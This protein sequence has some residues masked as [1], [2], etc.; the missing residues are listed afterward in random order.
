MKPASKPP[1]LARSLVLISVAALLVWYVARAF[2]GIPSPPAAPL[3]APAVDQSL[4][5]KSSTQVA[6]F[7][8]GC[9]WG[10]QAVFEHVIGV[11]KVTAG[12]CGGHVDHPYYE[13]VCTGSTGH[14]ESARVV[15]DPS[16]IT[17]G[18]LLMIFFGVAHDPT[19]NNRQGPDVGT[20]Y[21]SAIFYTTDEQ[22]KIA[23]AYIAQLDARKLFKHA[24]ATEL[25]HAP[26]FYDAEDYHQDYLVHHM[27]DG[28]I[29]AMD[30]P[31]LDRLK[32][33]FPQF[34]R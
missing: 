13:L 7:A 20:Q 4:A 33:D 21:R 28:Y 14:A 15:Y 31:K 32:R 18:Q 3:P 29:R 2:S 8:G 24:I 17:Y 6:I 5:A 9:F 34:Y 10:T 16:K 25:V 12:Y 19:Q 22:Q 1:L 27:D 30:L 26:E 11:Q 23:A